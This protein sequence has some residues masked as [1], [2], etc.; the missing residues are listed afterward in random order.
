MIK[1]FKEPNSKNTLLFKKE[2]GE[3][4]FVR[5]KTHKLKKTSVIWYNKNLVKDLNIDESK[6]ESEILDNFSYV[7]K[8]YTNKKNIFTN[9]SKFFLADRY[10]SRYEIC[11]GGGARCGSNG[12]FQI[13][14]IGANP[15]VSLQ[16]DEHHSH[17]KLCILEAVNEAIWGEVCHKNLP[18][19]AVRTLAIINTNTAIRS[20]YGLPEPRNL[21]C[22]LAI[23]QVSIRPAH[24][25]RAP[26]FFPKYEYQY[27]RDND[28]LRVK[29]AI[30]LLKDN[31]I[32]SKLHIEESLQNALS[33]F[34]I[35]L[36]KQIAAS[37]ILGIP[38]RSLTSSN[39]CIDTKFIDFG[40]ISAVP[41]FANYR[42]GH[43][44]YGVWDDH[45]LIVKWLHNFVFFINKYNKEKINDHDLKLLTAKFIENLSYFED[46]FLSD[47][48]RIKK[49]DFTKVNSFKVALQ[50]QP[51]TNWNRFDLMED[52]VRLANKMDMYVDK[53]AVFHLRHE[54]F[55]QKHIINQ[56]LRNISNTTIYD[57]SISDFINSY[58]NL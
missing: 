24:F 54:K 30:H 47:I 55:S 58:Q 45:K 9:D 26:F 39:I 18:Y 12:N 16:M 46:V 52:I 40:T 14:G 56:T 32:L 43:E 49:T 13:K 51:K 41:N 19:G 48:L 34:L 53:N 11:N 25:V 57:K 28:A 21:P 5:F 50:S 15:L 37:R 17:G 4:S 8:E 36:A 35:K 44:D 20:F 1:T 6:I 29:K 33:H 10:G 38:H 23:R 42:Y 3:T 2:L 7:T 31:L 22:V 27:L